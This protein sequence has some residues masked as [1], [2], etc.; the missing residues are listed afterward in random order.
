MNSF[1]IITA[2]EYSTTNKTYG[3]LIE[4]NLPSEK[5]VEKNQDWMVRESFL[6]FGP[7]LVGDLRVIKNDTNVFEIHPFPEWVVQIY[8]PNKKVGSVY[9]LVPNWTV[10]YIQE[11]GEMIWSDRL[12][13]IQTRLR[14][15]KIE[16]I[17]AVKYEVGTSIKI[18]ANVPH[19]FISVVHPGEEIPYCQVFEP[20]DS[21][22]VKTFKITMPVFQLPFSVK[23][24]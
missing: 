3:H 24:T 18:P 6:P 4:V 15:L 13:E 10:E 2:N 8:L 20:N 22:I 16:Q 14:I 5:M 9:A 23:I 17:I 21:G 7:L 11:L 19:E 12:I 1:K